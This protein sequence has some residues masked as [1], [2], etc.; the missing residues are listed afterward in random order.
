L[1]LN[2][3]G[4][5]G[6]TAKPWDTDLVSGFKML[7][8]VVTIQWNS[9]DGPRRFDLFTVLTANRTTETQ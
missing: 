1:D 2:G 3:N 4:S 8:V 5:D 7:P 6:T 9:A